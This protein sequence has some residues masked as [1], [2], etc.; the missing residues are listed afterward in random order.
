M[1]D[2]RDYKKFKEQKSN[3][4]SG[5]TRFNVQP[6]PS[7]MRPTF[8]EPS[9]DEFEE[10]DYESKLKRHK[11]KNV[12][13][14]MLGVIMAIV[15]VVY[16]INGINNRTY[17]SYTIM[18]S[19]TK[20]NVQNAKY[21]DFCDGY[22]RYSNDGIA[23]YDKK[24]VSL[25]NQTYQMKSPQISVRGNCMAV[26]D[27]NGSTIYM[28]DKKGMIGSVDTSLSISQVEMGEQ[29]VVAAILEDSNANYINLYD[30]TGEKIY[31]VK[32]TLSGDGYPLGIGISQDAT[33][34]IASYV[35]VSGESIKTNVVFYNFSDVGQNE[36]ERVVGGFDYESTLVPEVK[37]LTN[38]CAVA[39]GENVIGIYRIKEFP[40]LY[41]MIDIDSTINRVFTSDK[42][43]GLLLENKESGDNYRMLV[44]D[45][46]GGKVS[47][48]TFNTMYET[49]KFDGD[50]ILMYNSNLFTMKNCKGKTLFEQE[51]DLPVEDILSTNVKGNYYLVNSTYVQ[52]IHLK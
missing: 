12:L 36:T 34:L 16:V 49:I 41:K 2:I 44:Y 6:L 17:S 14:M 20:D 3:V 5:R 42:Y 18:S 33:K 24:G 50:T 1:A 15:L 31:S 30:E 46:N 11:I 47:E 40:S 22:V 35:Y 51:M 38:N 8:E 37:F 25:W 27:I 13:M 45:L 23:F 4:V 7:S 52:E 43:I 19:V 39:I 32:T 9:D 29:G 28:F 21:T 10:D 48:T 26:G